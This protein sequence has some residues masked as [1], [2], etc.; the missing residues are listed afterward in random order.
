[1]NALRALGSQV[2]CIPRA[3]LLTPFKVGENATCP[4]A[5]CFTLY[6]L[7]I[8]DHNVIT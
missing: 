3:R 2:G 1:M 7:S 8:S 6:F 4:A 5:C